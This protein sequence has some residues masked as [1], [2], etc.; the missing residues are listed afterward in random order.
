VA[1]RDPNDLHPIVR[2]K[3]NRLRAACKV[4]GFDIFFPQ[5]LRSPEEQAAMYAQGRTEPGKI[6]TH[7][8]PWESW[9][10]PHIYVEAESRYCCLAFDIAFRPI[11][12]PDTELREDLYGAT[13]DGPWEL[14][15]LMGE[16]LGLVWGG[17]WRGAKKDRPH[18]E[19]PLGRPLSWYARHR[20]EMRHEALGGGGGGVL[21][22]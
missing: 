2:E 6:I 4:L 15:G 1:T 20:D 21:E 17:R 10:Q 16:K 22:D 9:H 11:D 19:D 3:A 13:W 12:D 8:E 18:F 14:V 7:A 5:V